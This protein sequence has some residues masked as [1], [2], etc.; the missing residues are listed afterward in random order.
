MGWSTDLVVPIRG[1]TDVDVDVGVGVFEVG[2]E[3]GSGVSVG[4]VVGFGVVTSVGHPM[5][6]CAIVPAPTV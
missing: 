2:V 1:R 3:V 4:G 6:C 5:T